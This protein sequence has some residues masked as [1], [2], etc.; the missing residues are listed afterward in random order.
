M[1]SPECFPDFDEPLRAA[2]LRESELF[3]DAVVRED[4]SVLD[5]LD[6]DFTFVNER[7][8]RHYGIAGV[9]GNEFV[10][11]SLAGTPRAGVLTQGSVLVATSNPT[12]TSPVKRGKWILDNIL[13]TPPPAPPPGAGDLREEHMQLTSLRQRLERHRSDPGCA[14]CHEQMDPLGFGLESFDGIG[15]WRTRDGESDI[16]SSGT[17]PGG[18]S[19]HGPDQLRALLKSR[20]EPFARCLTEKLLTYALGRGIDPHERR[21]VDAIVR[22][23]AQKNYRFSALVLAIV[24]SDAF[25]SHRGGVKP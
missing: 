8:A 9:R 24:H 16:D 23:L 22:R 14:S 13:G 5:L 19:F 4:R 6:G 12:R 15:A 17:L 21:L 11:V 10:R 20:P 2:M 1:P 7:L 18:Q 25:Q 3:F